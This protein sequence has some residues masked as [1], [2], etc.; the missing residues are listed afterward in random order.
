MNKS[1]KIIRNILI[2]GLIVGFVVWK[3]ASNKHKM[4]EKT[5]LANPK[6]TIF[7]VTVL[8]VHEQNISEN[9]SVSGSFNPSRELNFVS[10]VTGRVVSLLVENGTVVSKGQTIAQ[11]DDEQVKNDLSLAE[12]DYKLA[13]DELSRF[14]N[15][16]QKDAVSKQ[17]VLDKNLAF[18]RAKNRLSTLQRNLRNTKIVA[19]ISGTINNLNLEVGSFLAAGTVISEI[20][21]VSNL[22]MTVKLA[23]NQIINI[24]KGQKVNVNADLFSDANYQGTVHT[25][26]VKADG[27]KKYD[28]E[29]NVENIANFPLKAGMTGSASF[30]SGKE[31]QAILIPKNILLNGVKNPS[32]FVVD[33]NN[34]A[35]AVSLVLGINVDENVEVIKGLN[36]GDKVV[37]S[38]QLNLSAGNKVEIIKL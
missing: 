25:I 28:V 31:K 4:A 1:V 11:L 16:L 32:V 26:S 10:E 30:I 21:D 18:N 7:P 6:L 22:K 12:V 38:G 33:K 36:I 15:M 27:A 37:T 19:P 8:D 23:D 5:E 35:H 24:K 34:E 29:V 9:F 2:A 14:K 17:Q 3:L 20:I 13:E